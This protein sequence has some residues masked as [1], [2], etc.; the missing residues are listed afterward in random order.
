[1]ITEKSDSWINEQ[2]R[3]LEEGFRGANNRMI[4]GL[5]VHPDATIVLAIENTFLEVEPP[6]KEDEITYHDVGV[7]FAKIWNLEI[8]R[9]I[10]QSV[11]FPREAVEATMAKEGGFRKNTVG[12]TL[13]EM[14]IVERHDDPHADITRCCSRSD[15]LAQ[16]IY[17]ILSQMRDFPR[18][19]I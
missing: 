7:V 16:V 14:G 8:I 1:L 15:I 19:H 4:H 9:M 3:G 5:R 12:Q 10:S 13:Q 6:T 18:A 17:V 11:P 2:P